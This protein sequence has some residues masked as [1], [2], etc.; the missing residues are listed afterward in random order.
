MRATLLALASLTFGFLLG[1]SWTRHAGSTSVA[2]TTA[3]S[4]AR[5]DDA[6]LAPQLEATSTQAPRPVVTGTRAPATAA[7]LDEANPS[8]LLANSE[9]DDLVDALQRALDAG[10]VAELEDSSPG[11]LVSQVLFIIYQEAGSLAELVPLIEF[12]LLSQHMRKG[13]IDELRGAGDAVG[14]TRLYLDWLALE[15]Y[16]KSLLNDLSRHDP[17]TLIVYFE[18]RPDLS[19]YPGVEMILGD[20]LLRAGREE[21][22]LALARRTLSENPEGQIGWHLLNRVAP[23]EALAVAEERAAESAEWTCTWAAELAE[24]GEVERAVGVLVDRLVDG[25]DDDLASEL[26]YLDA[27]RAAEFLGAWALQAPDDVELHCLWAEALSSAGDETGAV[28]ILAQL[29]AQ[30]PI[31]RD[32][33]VQG[34]LLS[35]DPERFFATVRPAVEASEDEH[36]WF[37]LAQLYGRAGQVD[38][39]RA[40]LDQA[41]E[42]DPWDRRYRD[43][44]RALGE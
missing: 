7:A 2:P 42:L 13:L 28:N 40:A 14:A 24:R 18:S 39:Q 11:W 43:A 30:D 34:D 6:L 15:P 12:E 3:A 41:I 38:E 21:E 16:N 4:V 8:E 10:W 37:D 25:R 32:W 33:S 22:A 36:E 9:I 26:S 44:R 29:L 17:A 27:G 19:T 35:L 5:S 23:E 31:D 1:S 20:S